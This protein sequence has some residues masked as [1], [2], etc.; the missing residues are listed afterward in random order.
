M[1]LL[2]II[3]V[4]L[5][6]T[7]FGLASLPEDLPASIPLFPEGSIDRVQDTGED[8]RTISF[9][10]VVDATIEEINEWYR[11]AMQ[12]DGWSMKSDQQIGPYTLLQAENGELYTSM[13][14]AN[15]ENGLVRITQV[16]RIGNGYKYSTFHRQRDEYSP[17][18]VETHHTSRSP[19]RSFLPM[20]VIPIVATGIGL[21]LLWFWKKIE[22][23]V[24]LFLRRYLSGSIMKKVKKQTTISAYKGIN[25]YNLRIKYREWLAVGI[26]ALVFA[27]ALSFNFTN[28]FYFLFLNFLV[29]VLVYG[30]ITFTRLFLDKHFD[31]H[32]EYKLWG[33]GA[34]VTV[35]TGWLGNTFSLAG[36]V[37]TDKASK[38][39]AF[40]NF[41]TSASYIFFSFI[42]ICLYRVIQGHFFRMSMV[43]MLSITLIDML[44][45][46]PFSGKI[47]YQTKKQL[48][49]ILFVPVALLYVVLVL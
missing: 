48:W 11:N 5:L 4:L 29:N 21:G 2:P 3:L 1:K 22:S 28:Y 37:I 12:R 23:F 39:P 36:Y 9:Q 17:P 13:Q 43:L 46:S 41:M 49:L 38:K 15:A 18:P 42:F 25:I 6:T 33:W 44:P 45:F 32:R 19:L 34:I 24:N 7:S 27:I 16:V 30:I 40:I 10:I 20:E 31:T 26:T 8:T 35:L 47:M 14:A